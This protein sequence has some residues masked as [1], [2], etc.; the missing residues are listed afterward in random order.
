MPLIQRNS[1]LFSNLV[2]TSGRYVNPV[3]ITSLSAAKVGSGIAQWNAAQLSGYG[4]NISSPSGG[5]VLLYS[6]SG[7][8]YNSQIPSGS[9]TEYTAESGVVL[10]GTAFSMGGSGNLNRLTFDNSIIAIGTNVSTTGK[11]GDI[12]I[13]YEAGPI[14]RS[15]SSSL[16]NVAIGTASLDTSNGYIAGTISIGYQAG[17]FM[18]SSTG[19][20]CVG[21]RSSYQLQSG[22]NCIS[23]GTFSNVQ[24]LNSSGSISIGEY[25][26]AYSTVSNS[27]FVGKYLGQYASGSNNIF[28]GEKVGPWS[29][30]S[31]KFSTSNIFIGFN[32]NGI[33]GGTGNIV[34]EASGQSC[35][36]YGTSSGNYKI[37]IGSTI[38]GDSQEKRL[39]I[40][41]VTSGQLSPNG[42][43]EILP[44]LSTDTVL[45]ARG[46][47]L[48][49]GNLIEGRESNG[50]T[51]FSVGPSGQISGALTPGV[52]QSTGLILSDIH[53]GKIIEHT[54]VASGTYTIGSIT[55]P[56]WQCMF[57]NFGSGINIA[58]GS[59]V[60]R[61]YSG[62]SNIS[63]LYSSASM[64]RRPNGE[65]FIFGDIN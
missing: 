31:K 47:N 50:G 17:K 11:L 46:T 26:G 6:D 38:A 13:G 40:G 61:S 12:H 28:I 7:Y 49:S 64:Y 30:I 57:V 44:K 24:S 56:S 55:I 51:V 27:I 8:W 1:I 23:I 3:W 5:D 32:T 58:S 34:I 60:I 36:I 16:S 25:A 39:A 4:L 14:V 22:I 37:S 35:P 43:L 53:H 42:T 41:N 20:I 59:N 18:Q 48:Q 62:Y 54:G 19:V 21:D 63:N 33:F 9:P 15:T 52:V 10:S 2:Y 65:F 29:S 45:I